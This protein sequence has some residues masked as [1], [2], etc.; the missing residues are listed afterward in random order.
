MLVSILLDDDDDDD[1]LTTDDGVRVREL[2]SVCGVMNSA[3]VGTP[4]D[5]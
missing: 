1:G 5:C 3:A 2:T 4:A